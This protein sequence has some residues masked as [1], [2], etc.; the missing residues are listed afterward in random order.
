MK[1]LKKV[2][3]INKIYEFAVMLDLSD[4]IYFRHA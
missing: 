3:Y 4:G 1:I 2:Y